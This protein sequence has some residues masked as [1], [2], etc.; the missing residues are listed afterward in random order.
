MEPEI[1]D[2]ETVGELLNFLKTLDRDTA[3]M[4]KY[5]ED[6]R[7]DLNCINVKEIRFS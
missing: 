5:G 7:L 6:L 2:F 1:K 4:N 3:V